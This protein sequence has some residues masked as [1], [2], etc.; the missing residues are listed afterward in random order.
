MGDLGRVETIEIGAT[1][2]HPAV[3]V[4]GK[5]NLNTVCCVNGLLTLNKTTGKFEAYQTT[6]DNAVI[7]LEE[8]KET[9]TNAVVLLHGTFDSS[10]VRKANGDNLTTLELAAVQSKSQIYFV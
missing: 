9:T 6:S 4:T 10:L 3:K 2:G 1:N 7:A 8:I 5:I